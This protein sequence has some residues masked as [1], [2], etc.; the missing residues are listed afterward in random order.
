MPNVMAAL[1]NIG[2]ALGHGYFAE[3]ELQIAECGKLSRG[4]LQ[5]IK[6]GKFCKLLLIAFPHSTAEKFCISADCKTTVRSRCTT[7]VQP[8]HSSVRHPA[9][10]SFRRPLLSGPFA[11]QQGSCFTISTNFKVSRIP[12]VMSFR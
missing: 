3:C 10:L 12:S 2:G 5:K 8:M 9:V 6:C 1:P 11:K 4:N 7:D